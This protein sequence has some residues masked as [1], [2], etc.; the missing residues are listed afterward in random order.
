MIDIDNGVINNNFAINFF[1]GYLM[2][3]YDL[4]VI[5]NIE[6]EYLIRFLEK[7]LDK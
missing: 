1:K 7:L 3:M 2:A 6:R 5:N 4:N